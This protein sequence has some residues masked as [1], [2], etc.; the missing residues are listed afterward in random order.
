[1]HKI[2]HPAK[3]SRITKSKI[4]NTNMA[5]HKKST[6]SDLIRQRMKDAGI[7]EERFELQIESLAN[8]MDDIAKW[9]S[10]VKKEGSV[11]KELDS[12]LNPK[13]IA[14]PL[15]KLIN[16][17]KKLE[18]DQMAALKLNMLRERPADGKGRTTDS[19]VEFIDGL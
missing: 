11:I 7:Y 9:R 6:T 5:A 2:V 16:D 3:A 15:L 4:K 17:A 10:I 12:N 18:K 1:M 8:T 14:H 13:R 19:L